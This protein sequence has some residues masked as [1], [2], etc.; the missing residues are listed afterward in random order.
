MVE[1]AIQARAVASRGE[2]GRF[3]VRAAKEEGSAGWR[4]LGT[5][6]KPLWAACEPQMPSLQ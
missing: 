5:R 4:V 6:G 1:N 3:A 2:H